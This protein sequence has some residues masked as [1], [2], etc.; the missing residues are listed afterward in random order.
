[1]KRGF[2]L[3]ELL[4]VIA[5]IGV[6][7]S[8][9][10][11][12]LNTSRAKARDAQRVSHLREAQK[13]LETYANDNGGSYPNTSLSWKSVCN[14]Y[15]QQFVVYDGTLGKG[16]VP[17]YLPSLPADPE[18]SCGGTWATSKCVYSYA[19]DGIDYD[20]MLYNCPTANTANPKLAPLLD[21]I[22]T[23]SWSVHT[24]GAQ[25]KNL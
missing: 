5:I 6:L 12:S 25:A 13:A 24:A 1:M 4:V 22:F 17:T 15:T 14:G 2:T 16:I 9:V 3:I 11:V 10:L 23:T 19:S 20:L 7:S 21:P 8:I 18:M